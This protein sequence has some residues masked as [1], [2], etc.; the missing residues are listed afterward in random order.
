MMDVNCIWVHAHLDGHLDRTLGARER[1]AM[2]AHL[3]T[4]DA[5]HEAMAMTRTLTSALADIDDIEL[6]VGFSQRLSARLHQ[7]A[8]LI[9]QAGR[10]QPDIRPRKG[11]WSRL[12]PSLPVKPL[13]GV[14]AVAMLVVTVLLMQGVSLSPVPGSQSASSANTSAVPVSMTMGGDA[15]VRVWFESEQAVDHVR[16][17]LQLPPGVRMV[18]DGQVVDSATLTWEGKLQKGR[19]LIPLRVRGIAHGNWTVTASIEKG[20]ARRAK[21]IDLQVSGI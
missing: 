5:C 14:A 2:K 10:I 19:N 21:S 13:A 12:F 18:S 6:P 20:G 7:E 3:A 8:A 15:V 17:S 1:V 11:W 9:Q 16:F 4:C